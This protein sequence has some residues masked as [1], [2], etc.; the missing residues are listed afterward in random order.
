[1][2]R[3]V[4]K[5]D[6]AC[7]KQMQVSIEVADQLKQVRAWRL[8]NCA[9]ELSSFDQCACVNQLCVCVCV[10]LSLSVLCVSTQLQTESQIL[11][12]A[13]RTE[14]MGQQMTTLVEEVRDLKLYLVTT[15]QTAPSVRFADAIDAQTEHDPDP[16]S[17]CPSP[18]VSPCL[19]LSPFA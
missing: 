3:H 7:D 6:G 11:Q 12:N 1:M 8:E 13:S 2:G 5:V 9:F 18:H 16:L 10:C 14:T 19:S 17:L 15:R 4:M